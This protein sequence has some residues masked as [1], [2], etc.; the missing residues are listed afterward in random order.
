MAKSK[1]PVTQAIRFLRSQ[2]IDFSPHTYAYGDHGGA[3]QAAAALQLPAHYVVKTLVMQTGDHA[4]FLMLMH[5]DQT[6]ST[7]RLA[8][9]MGTKQVEPANPAN[10]Q[11]CT[12]YRVGGISPFG[13][14]TSMPVY[15]QATILALERIYINGGKRG[16]LVEIDPAT[17]PA[18]LNAIAVDAVVD[19][20]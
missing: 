2:Q 13:T 7:K 9:A 14:R 10:A 15:V 18:T 5:G 8:R 16:F 3:V 1:Y 6:V 4:P 11:R 17:L 12:G 20:Q 19:E